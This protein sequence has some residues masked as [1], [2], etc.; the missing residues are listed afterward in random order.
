MSN[1]VELDTVRGPQHHIDEI[2]KKL[3]FK[4]IIIVG[5]GEDDLI[6]TFVDV[7]L[8]DMHFCYMIDCL[9][10]RRRARLDQ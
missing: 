3:G 2:K 6:H 4:E 9:K 10:E 5:F 8:V 7:D 1:I